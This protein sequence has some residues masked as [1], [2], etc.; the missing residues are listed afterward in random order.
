MK[1][2]IRRPKA[3]AKLSDSFHHALN[4][5]ALAAGAAGVSVLAL[6]QPSEA[7]IIYTPTHQF[8]GRRGA[9]R[10]DLNH[11]GV[12]DFTIHD[13]CLITNSWVSNFLKV[14]PAQGN[15]VLLSGGR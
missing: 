13:Q 9:Y 8:I 5:Y 6:A 10:I 4:L 11:D 1:R 14:I 3:P 7:E 12:T 15:A 2:S